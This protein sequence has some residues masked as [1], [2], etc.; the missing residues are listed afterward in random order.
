MNEIKKEFNLREKVFLR[1]FCYPPPGRDQPES[2]G[3]N[4]TEDPLSWLKD[5]F[6]NSFTE[7]IK[8]K[9]VLDV[10]CGGGEQVV[11]AV[12]HGAKCAVGSE[13][14]AIFNQS[15]L[16]AKELGI[17][18]KVM[19]TLSPLRELGEQTIDVAFSQNSFEHFG[20]PAQILRDVF[21]VLKKGG[22][23]FV[24]FS[25]PWFH[26]F[27]VHM[28]FM[29]KYPWTHFIF[30]EKTILKVR[31]LYRNDGAKTF[32][33]TEGGLNKM[34]IGRFMRLSKSAGYKVEFLKLKPIMILPRVLTH[35]AVIREFVTSSMS[36]VLYK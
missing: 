30:S 2:A 34:T 15:L 20:E 6:G 11:G 16:R 19:F 31:S 27:G 4:S 33:E 8:G 12:L 13:I 1:F 23:F 25:P 5:R 14:R 18:E 24:T 10:G 32:A 21:F 17:G 3:E 7:S 9:T 22:R 36:V 29:I 35:M 26:P 28:F